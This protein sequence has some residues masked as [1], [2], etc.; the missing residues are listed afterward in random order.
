MIKI[1][2]LSILALLA[3]GACSTTETSGTLGFATLEETGESVVIYGQ[4]EDLRGTREAFA[5]GDQIGVSALTPGTSDLKSPEM[6]NIAYVADG[7]GIFSGVEGGIKLDGAPADIVAYYPYSPKVADGLLPVDISDQTDASKTDLLWGKSLSSDL[8]SG[9]RAPM[10]FLHKLGLVEITFEAKDAT[11]GLPSSIKVTAK[12]VKYAGQMALATG[13]LTLGTETKDIT[14]AA[15]ADH[16]AYL[17]LMPGD[18]LSGLAFDFDGQ[19]KEFTFDAPLEI[20]SGKRIV[21][22]FRPYS[23]AIPAL[24]AAYAEIPVETIEHPGT[25]RAIHMAPDSWFAGGTTPGGSRRNYSILYDKEKK[26]PLWVAYPMYADCKGPQER[27]NYWD[28]DPDIP[29]ADQP[30]LEGSYQPQSMDFNRG[31]MLSS[32]SRD[33]SLML[34]RS[35]FYY[36]NMVPQNKYQNSGIWTQLETKEQAWIN[37]YDTLFIVCGPIFDPA[38]VKRYVQDDVNQNV[39]VPDAVFK[40]ILR[41]TASG[42]WQSMAVRMP[43]T[44]PSSGDSWKNHMVTVRSLEEEL[45]FTFFTHLPADVATEVKSQNN[46]AQ[47]N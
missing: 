33:A 18:K 42:E 32:E 45:G 26:Q 25:I 4:K 3:L 6:A 28:W 30:Q 23:D 46:P 1:P 16:K 11:H 2:S 8:I 12:G 41:Q 47:W 38:A 44:K 43:N 40:A 35:T 37:S 27:T 36:T 39:L 19:L 10:T 13:E 14:V 17:L 5:A 21:L 15:D 24:K 20:V 7:N 22:T 34:N 9:Y 29:R 31:H